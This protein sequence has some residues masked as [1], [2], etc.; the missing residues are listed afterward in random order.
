MATTAKITSQFLHRVA[1]EGNDKINMMEGRLEWLG[2]LGWLGGG[3][4][5][6]FFKWWSRAGLSLEF[7]YHVCHGDNRYW[8]HFTSLN[9][10]RNKTDFI[11]NRVKFSCSGSD[12]YSDLPISL[13]LTTMLFFQF[14][15][16]WAQDNNF[17]FKNTNENLTK[18]SCQK[19]ASVCLILI[20]CSSCTLT[21]LA[22]PNTMLEPLTAE[23]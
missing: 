21:S 2:W 11:Q 1:S 19:Q 12:I 3:A 23:H 6:G 17:A 13:Q 5:I 16:N 10:P 18:F 15:W 9:H 8:L 14:S 22:A 20:L 4:G 7:H